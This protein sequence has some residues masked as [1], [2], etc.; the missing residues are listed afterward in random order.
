[1]KGGSNAQGKKQSRNGVG[2]IA[3]IALI[4]VGAVV[5]A[6]SAEAAP[7]LARGTVF[8]MTNDPSDN[9]ILVF[10]RNPNGRLI[11]RGRVS[12]GGLGNGTMPDALA[13]PGSL[14]RSGNFLFAVNAGSDE[15]SVLAI[16]KKH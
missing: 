7:N 8:V 1:M 3:L 12:T 13:S 9:S 2:W 4:T 6:G 11:A 10:Q 5:F 16:G 15:I 14:V